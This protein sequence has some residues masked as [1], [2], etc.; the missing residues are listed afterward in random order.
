MYAH[1]L[2]SLR[3]S[4]T[5]WIN[6]NEYVTVSSKMYFAHLFD[7]DFDLNTH[8]GVKLTIIFHGSRSS[9]RNYTKQGCY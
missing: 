3:I 1:F 9:L 4:L 6:N 5:I 7:L 2:F 8:L